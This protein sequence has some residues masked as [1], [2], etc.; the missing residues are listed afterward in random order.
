MKPS[1]Q[2][3]LDMLRRAESVCASD[4]LN[5]GIGRYGARVFELRNQHDFVISMKVCK[6]HSHPH[7]PVYRYRLEGKRVPVVPTS[8]EQLSIEVG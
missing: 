2:I 5:R 8:A 4:F 3:V 6:Q 7:G 1:T